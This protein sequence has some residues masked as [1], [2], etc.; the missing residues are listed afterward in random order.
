VAINTQTQFLEVI[1]ALSQSSYP[2]IISE[3]TDM[4]SIKDAIAFTKKLFNE[5]SGTNFEAELIGKIEQFLSQIYSLIQKNSH[6]DIIK[7]EEITELQTVMANTIKQRDALER[8]LQ[9]LDH[10]FSQKD[11][12]HSDMHRLERLQHFIK[13]WNLAATSGQKQSSFD[14]LKAQAP[15]VK[16]LGQDVGSYER[17][18]ASRLDYQEL[19]KFRKDERIN[20]I[21]NLIKEEEARLTTQFAPQFAIEARAISN[22]MMVYFGDVKS[23]K[24]KISAEEFAKRV[25]WIDGLV[26]TLTDPKTST[27]F[28]E[29]VCKQK[30]VEYKKDTANTQFGVTS[31][32]GKYIARIEAAHIPTLT[33]GLQLKAW[34]MT[35]N[36]ILNTKDPSIMKRK[37]G[38]P[39]QDQAIAEAKKVIETV[40]NALTDQLKSPQIDLARV[41][42]KANEQK[43]EQLRKWFDTPD[44]ERRIPSSVGV[45]SAFSVSGGESIIT[46]TMHQYGAAICKDQGVKDLYAEATRALE[47]FKAAVQEAVIAHTPIIRVHHGISEGPQ[48]EKQWEEQD[49]E[50][51]NKKGL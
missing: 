48:T 11:I 28:S 21:I 13:M 49:P 8:L 33:K 44:T 39:N 24:V 41:N 7:L 36:S 19:H 30:F 42:T 20:S 26:N 25:D 22:Q 32:F 3:L 37:E 1:T 40:K 18:F 43:M 46:P 15:Q 51:S 27:W 4:Q 35:A 23:G 9:N 38:M 10:Y 45:F 2:D 12:R 17:K 6:I 5:D 29:E 31:T 50:G 14:E 47:Q 34:K 16:L